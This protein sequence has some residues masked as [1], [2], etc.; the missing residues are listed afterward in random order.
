MRLPVLSLVLLTL[1]AGL[2]A[3]EWVQSL[4]G[5]W[6]FTV[7]GDQ[8]ASPG[9]GWGTITVPGNWDVMPEY[10]THVGKG[11]YR[12]TF[13]PG[14]EVA[15]KTLRLRFEAVYHDAQVTLNGE[16]LGTHCG[17]Y[18]PFEFDV[19]G[20]V[21][22]GAAN[23][24]VVQADNSYQRGAWWHWG[25]I[26][27][28]VALIANDPVR[29]AWQHISAV[30]DLAAGTATVTVR[31]RIVNAGSAPA[32]VQVASRL[33]QATTDL[34]ACEAAV[35]AGQAVEVEGRAV[36]SKDQVRLW[37]F[38]HPNLYRL[39]TRATT[40]GA[41]QH[42]RSDR[43]GI[44]SVTITPTALVLNGEPMRVVGFNRV[45]DHPDHGNTEPDALVRA[46]VTL[47]KRAGC[48]FTRI[49]HYPQA[50]N[51]LDHLDEQGMMIVCEIPVW[52]GG[53]PQVKPGNQL[54][55]QWMAEMMARDFNHPSI[56][57]WSVANEIWNHAAYTTDMMAYVRTL[58]PGRLVSYASNTAANPKN[59][60]DTFDQADL[61]MTNHYRNWTDPAR[62]E[63]GRW[64]TKGVFLSEFGMGQFTTSELPPGFIEQWQRLT[65]GNP[66]VIG[67]SLWTFNDYRS[68]YKGT[69][70]SGYRMWGVVDEQRKPKKA[71]E[72]IRKL[73][74]PLRTF[75]VTDRTVRVEVRRP[76]E[77]P[78]YTLRGYR[79]TWGGGKTEGM[80]LPDLK[81]GDPAWTGTLPG[82]AAPGSAVRLM[83]PTGYDV[84]VAV[85]EAKR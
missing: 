17:G 14:P 4:D 34:I 73:F 12:R 60:F 10:A 71:Y 76:D 84:D 64:P 32:T 20:K 19:T 78:S 58:D 2:P 13:T 45:S 26:S 23:V 7:K 48:V 70:P 3:G 40:G 21:R 39:T 36:L 69:Q 74:S 46:D 72:Q 35:P 81:P 33:D 62:F 22:M 63:A 77:I 54:T 49:M 44:R 50:P 37:H 83:T 9:T 65:P 85:I 31:Y 41:V 68:S 52:G 57:G 6:Q 28:S 15:G 16:V 80:D 43:F 75:V 56:V 42:E 18:T 82:S 1:G 55:R 30:P 11:W 38:D 27:R 25:G 24:V 79:L 29:L 47:M 66:R 53:D 67:A 8:A 5:P 61:V 59:T 51:L